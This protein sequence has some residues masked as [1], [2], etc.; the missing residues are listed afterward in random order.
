MAC[1]VAWHC[2]AGRAASGCGLAAAA[3]AINMGC[4]ASSDAL[5]PL[6]RKWPAH[7]CCRAVSET[8]SSRRVGARE[9]RAL[10][11]LILP[12]SEPGNQVSS[13]QGPLQARH[14]PCAGTSAAWQALSTNATEQS[15]AQQLGVAAG[16]FCT[17]RKM[18]C[19]LS[20]LQSPAQRSNVCLQRV[21]TVLTRVLA[22]HRRACLAML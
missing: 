10:R 2:T 17:T 1:T 5:Q 19:F 4:T 13:T 8:S 3:K 18:G 15:L 20:E 22:S 16:A 9:V 11:L 6:A 12:S 14:T 21:S 7:T